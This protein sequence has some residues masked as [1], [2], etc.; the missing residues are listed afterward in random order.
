M[1]TYLR[2]G[3]LGRYLVYTAGFGAV[4]FRGST[5]GSVS[6]RG[7]LILMVDPRQLGDAAILTAH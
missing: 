6:C 3:Y 5:A 7:G 1:T 2:L 4:S